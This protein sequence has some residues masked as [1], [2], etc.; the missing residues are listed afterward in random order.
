MH[1]MATG[2]N[3]AD[4]AAALLPLQVQRGGSSSC[5]L[6][7]FD[8][9]PAL[10]LV[11]RQYRAADPRGQAKAGTAPHIVPDPRHELSVALLEVRTRV[12]AHPLEQYRAPERV[13]ADVLGVCPLAWAP[14]S[15]LRNRRDA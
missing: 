11:E 13:C 14:Q 12:P 5:R 10:H 15:R 8:F 7:L 4:R 2:T 3:T 9:Q 1:T 6:H